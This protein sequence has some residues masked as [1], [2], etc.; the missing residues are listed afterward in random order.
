MKAAQTQLGTVD[1]RNVSAVIPDY[2][3]EKLI[4]DGDLSGEGKDIADYFART[5]LKSTLGAALEQLQIGGNV[6]GSL[7]RIFRWMG[8]WCTPAVTWC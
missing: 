4:I 2:L 6:R 1:A 7:N 5:P 3:K 8:N